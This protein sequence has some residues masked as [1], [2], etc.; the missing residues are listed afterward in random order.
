MREPTNHDLLVWYLWMK[1]D[2]TPHIESPDVINQWISE[3][4]RATMPRGKPEA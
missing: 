4:S 1:I 3:V 2:E